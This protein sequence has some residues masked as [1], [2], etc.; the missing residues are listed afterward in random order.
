MQTERQK[1][2]LDSALDLIS[3]KGMQGLTIKNLAKSIGVTEPAIYRHYE[4]KMEILV[5]ILDLFKINTYHIYEKELKDDYSAVK[6]IEHLFI[7]HFDAFSES[8]ALVSVIFAEEIFRGEPSLIEKI[9]ELIERNQSAISAIIAE[10]QANGE[11]RT[12][13]DPKHLA[14]LI[15]GSLRLFVKKWQFSGYSFNI[16][17]E[18]KELLNSLKIMIIK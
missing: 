16:N 8:P 11:I 6:K 12:D 15:L 14:I 7:R 5:S 13:I 10:G 1:E 4:N 18:G 2:I 3:K 9:S 17:T